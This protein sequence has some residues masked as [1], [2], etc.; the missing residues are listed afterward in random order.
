M[1]TRK[2]NGQEVVVS[3]QEEAQI[4]EEWA[5]NDA[6]EQARQAAESSER[7]RRAALVSQI[8]AALGVSLDDL[9]DALRHI[10]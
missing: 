7:S 9:R 5:R 2:V 3:A 4:R 10:S 8:E 1:L 6:A